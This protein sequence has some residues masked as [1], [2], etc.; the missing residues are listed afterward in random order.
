MLQAHPSLA[1]CIVAFLMVTINNNLAFCRKEQRMNKGLNEHE[2]YVIIRPI[3][4]DCEL[5]TNGFPIIKKTEYNEN[6]W[7]DIDATNLQ[8]LSCKSNNDRRILLMFAHDYRLENLWNNPLK[9]VAL[10]QTFYAIATPDFS[11]CPQMNINDLRHN[12][13]KSRWLGRTW[14]NYGCTVFPTIQWALP[15]TYDIAFG[16]IEKGCVVVISTLGCQDN[17]EVFLDGFNEMKRRLEPS[18]IIVYGKMISGMTGKFVNYS[19]SDTFSRDSVQLRIEGISQVF[20]IK[21]N[22]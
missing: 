11:I 9:K 12:V 19:Y 22:A 14:Q 1:P 10:F 16:G 15:D 4:G 3:I 6:E 5:D 20:E 17:R 13:Y 2:K 7:Y 18:L 21:E 8:N